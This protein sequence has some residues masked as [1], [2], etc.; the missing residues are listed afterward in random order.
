MEEKKWDKI[1]P[2]DW[3]ENFIEL[4]TGI[5]L[6]YL[7]MGPE[8]GKKLILIHGATDSRLTFVNLA[9]YLSQK[10]FNLYIIELR[11]HGKTSK[12]IPLNKSYNLTD[13]TEDIKD[14][15]IKLNLE[16]FS[17]GGHSLGSFVAAR[18][19]NDFPK[20][21]ENLILL[22]SALDGSKSKG[23][24]IYFKG[25]NDFK[26]IHGYEKEK[27]FP[28]SFLKPWC[29]CDTEK[30]SEAI[31]LQCKELGHDV[32][33]YIFDGLYTLDNTNYVNNITARVFIIWGE[34][35]IVFLK[36]EQEKLKNSLINS[37]EVKIEILK[38]CPHNMCVNKKFSDNVCELISNF[39]LN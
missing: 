5:K 28:D 4:K 29:Q 26:G 8:N 36:N 20:K 2:L 19:A 33:C 1:F 31:Y 27:I 7:K 21:V 18:I 14:F 10:G 30:L 34:N 22:G 12:P 24:D 37:K 15:I 17:I 13:Y 32:I 9:P 38:D 11:G 39:I 25:F 16:K 35:D 3:E 6:C 23:L